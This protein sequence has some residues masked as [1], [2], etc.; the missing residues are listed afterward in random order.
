MESS[1][2]MT[3]KETPAFTCMKQALSF[4]GKLL[5]RA[6]EFE[7]LATRKPNNSGCSTGQMMT[8]N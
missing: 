7:N 6:A 8:N 2:W 5:A 1:E 4:I 3:G